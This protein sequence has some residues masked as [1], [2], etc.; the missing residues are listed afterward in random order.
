[1]TRLDFFMRLRE[2]LHR[3]PPE[4]I[5]NAVRYYVEYFDEAGPEN[6]QRVLEEL[7]DPMKI[8]QQITAEYMVRAI[9]PYRPAPDEQGP[10]ATGPQPPRKSGLSAVWIAILAVFASPIALPVAIAIAAV[11]FALVV[12]VACV[13]LSFFGVSVGMMAGG[14]FGMVVG[15]LCLGAH[16]PTGICAIGSGMVVSGVG[17]LLFLPT[18]WLTRATFSGI[19]RLISRRVVRRDAA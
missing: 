16:V 13:F 10:E 11:A 2:G 19:A 14:V 7:G 6:E 8:A 15:I 9:E 3:L 12:V 1:M 18:V 17:L 4:E 5:E